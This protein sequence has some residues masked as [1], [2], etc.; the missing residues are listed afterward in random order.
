M[1]VKRLWQ[2]V[3][4]AA[5]VAIIRDWSDRRRIEDSTKVPVKLVGNGRYEGSQIILLSQGDDSGQI[6]GLPGGVM[7]TSSSSSR[8]DS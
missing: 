8:H 7:K 4:V 1:V 5:V 3:M 6:N 2:P